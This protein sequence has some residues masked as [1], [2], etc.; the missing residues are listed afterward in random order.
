MSRIFVRER[1]KVGRGEGKPRFVVSA[2]EGLDL[3]IYTIHLRKT[4]LNALA[5]AVGAEII[6]LPRGED[7]E[8][9][10]WQE[11]GGG[12]KKR[13]HRHRN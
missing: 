3:K 6:Y 12:G 10:E 7:S 9:E 1:L 8:E 4:E 13:R 11:K 5:E 2:T